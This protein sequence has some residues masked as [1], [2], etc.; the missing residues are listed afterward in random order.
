[1][2]SVF[3][4]LSFAALAGQAWARRRRLVTKFRHVQRP[5]E[6]HDDGGLEREPDEGKLES[7]PD[8]GKLEREPDEGELESENAAGDP[9]D[10]DRHEGADITGAQY[11]LN[12]SATNGSFRPHGSDDDSDSNDESD[13]DSDDEDA[14]RGTTVALLQKYGVIGRQSAL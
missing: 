5:R 10:D 11:I 1:M 12:F 7:E 8:E 3:V 14:G 4:A 6:E 2:L 9:D 13:D